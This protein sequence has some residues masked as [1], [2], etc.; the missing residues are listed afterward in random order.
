MKK[1]NLSD[2]STFLTQH[3]QAGRIGK[4]NDHNIHLLKIKGEFIWHNHEREDQLFY[5]LDG[6]VDMFFKENGAEKKLEL[7]KG[8]MIVI[9]KGIDHKP[10]ARE[11]ALVLSIEP[12]T[13][14]NTGDV[15]DEKFSSITRKEI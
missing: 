2:K 6:A 5:V 13:F 8:E 11:E 12:D 7:G 1:I 10:I 15:Y 14:V 9:P 4:L 3:W